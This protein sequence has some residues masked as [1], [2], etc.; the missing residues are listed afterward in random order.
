MRYG[1]IALAALGMIVAASADALPLERTISSDPLV[2]RIADLDTPHHFDRSRYGS[3]DTHWHWR[4]R[5]AY[6]RWL[7]SE[8]VRA[9]YP[10]R[11]W[12]RKTHVRGCCRHGD[13]HR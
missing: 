12:S 2:L 4:Y 11:H 9:G 10:V 1:A 5:A 6:T 7:H 3:T 13:R 8:Y